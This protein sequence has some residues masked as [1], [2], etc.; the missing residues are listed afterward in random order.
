MEI[1][2]T[3]LTSNKSFGNYSMFVGIILVII[4]ATGAVLPEFMAL[5]AVTFI[6][7]FMLIAAGAWI[8][9]TFKYARTSVKEWLKP[10]LLLGFGIYLISKP[11]IGIASLGLILSFYLMMDAFASFILAQLRYPEKGWGWM[12][13]NGV[14]SIILA[15]LFLIGWPATS[16]WLV[17]LYIAINLFFNGLSLTMIGWGIKKSVI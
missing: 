17:G 2:E 8:T 4:G 9:H 12:V 11:I 6:A 14:F 10:I 7:V 16:I 5:E 1:K 15:S 3:V 13:F